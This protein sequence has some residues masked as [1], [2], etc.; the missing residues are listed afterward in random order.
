MKDRENGDAF[1]KCHPLI[2]FLYFISVIAFSMFFMNPILLAISL[3]SALIYSFYL[4]GKKVIS[5]N[6]GYMTLLI[7]SISIINPIINHRGSTILLYINSKPIT[8]ESIIFGIASGIML[9]AVLLWFSSYN[10]I[11]TSDKFIY[12]FG[13][14]IPS[15]SLVL[16]MVLRF[17]PTFKKRVAT[18]SKTQKSIGRDI[19]DGHV[20]QR[21]NNGV[22]IM[23]ILTTWS[24]ENAI[25]TADSMKAR[26]YGL[27]G[28]TNFSIYKFKSRDSIALVALIV[29]NINMIYGA[30]IGVNTTQYF[31]QISIKPVDIFS[32]VVYISYLL[33][34]LLPLIIDV[35]EEIKWRLLK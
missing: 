26:G 7:V 30:L 12:L 13:R 6:I 2:N 4:K 24:L 3:V 8:M 25:E 23:S 16:S 21:I 28:R 18:I 11:M 14:I 22:K 31:P 9:A 33:L 1:S 27:K 35:L 34:C 15:T 5:F 19:T 20:F 10:E 17:V 32:I 29:L